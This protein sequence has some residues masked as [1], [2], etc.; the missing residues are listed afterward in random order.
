M[1]IIINFQEYVRTK[2]KKCCEVKT[3]NILNKN[4][5]IIHFNRKDVS[6]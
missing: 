2:K 3:S 6:L 5:Q 4:G 1:A